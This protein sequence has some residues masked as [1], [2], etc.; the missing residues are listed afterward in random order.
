MK[1]FVA[2]F[3]LGFAICFAAEPKPMHLVFDVSGSM[4]GRVQDGQ[5]EAGRMKIEVAREALATLLQTW[6]TQQPL[7]F[8]AYGH[9]RKGDCDDI[10]TLVPTG[11]ADVTRLLAL[12][13]TLQPKGKTPLAAAVR[14]AAEESGYQ[15]R[16]ATIVLLSDGI[17]TCA[18]DPCALIKDLAAKGK[19]LTLHVIG[20]DVTPKDAEQ[21]N[22]LARA[23]GGSYFAAADAGQLADAL[24]EVVAI[25][26]AAA[27]PEKLGDATVAAPATIEAGAPFEAAWTGP[28][29]RGDRLLIQAPA[30]DPAAGALETGYLYRGS[31]VTMRAPDT[32]GAYQ[33]RYVTGRSR[34]ALAFAAIE[35]VP[36]SAELTAPAVVTAGTMVEV[37]WRGPGRSGEHIAVFKAGDFAA[38]VAP[39]SMSYTHRNPV[40]LRV[41]TTAGDYEL[42]YLTARTRASLGAAAF[43]VEPASVQ[44]TAPDRFYAGQDLTVSFAGGGARGDRILWYGPLDGA[45]VVG[46]GHYANPNK[47][48]LAL[49]GPVA[50]GRY[51]FQYHNHE[52]TVLARLP[53]DVVEG[54]VSVEGPQQAPIGARIEVTWRGPA[55]TGDR[56]QVFAA[57][58]ELWQALYIGG[59]KSVVA[60]DVPSLPGTYRV[61]YVNGRSKAVMAE[62]PLTVTDVKLV[63]QVPASAAAGSQITLSW[64]GAD[65]PTDQIRLISRAGDKEKN[66]RT[67]YVQGRNQADLRL[68]KEPGLYEVQYLVGVKNRRVIATAPLRV[69]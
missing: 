41:P 43:R 5:S 67:V 31:P 13:K 22:C 60:V 6:D 4:W 7:G 15:K 48:E 45:A 3:F 14:H 69:E 35:V 24:T 1:W 51:E 12:V 52:K 32:P 27:E 25:E 28:N 39:L 50:P 11:P 9:R 65:S 55:G 21:L 46:D 66:V 23:A 63:W 20:F 58:G 16:A 54:F 57:D 2:L 40:S 64:Q 18:D 29:N 19:Q 49:R 30:V 33:V 8:T 17:E 26:A 61:A 62:Y 44:L 59:D 10:E 42:H 34:K 47:R 37:A 68:P 53:F 56:L 38:G 36:V